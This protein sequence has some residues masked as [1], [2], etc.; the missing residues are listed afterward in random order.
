MT[1]SPSKDTDERWVEFAIKDFKRHPSRRKQ[2]LRRMGNLG[3]QQIEALKL[4][5]N[6]DDE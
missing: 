5:E 2:Y 1:E 6:W 3:Y 4:A